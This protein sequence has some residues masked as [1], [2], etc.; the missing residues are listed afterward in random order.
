MPRILT[1]YICIHLPI[2]SRWQRAKVVDDTPTDDGEIDVFFVD[3]GESE[4]I[5]RED[6]LPIRSRFLNLPFQAIECN[7]MYVEPREEGKNNL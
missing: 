6:L 3:T 5:R 1:E 4:F 2:H 7:L